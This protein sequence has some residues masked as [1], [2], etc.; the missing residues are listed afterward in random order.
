MMTNPQQSLR[1]AVAALIAAFALTLGA[2]ASRPGPSVLAPV[3]G[4]DGTRLVTVFVAS[5]RAR[6]MSSPAL[7]TNQITT[8]PSYVRY[9]ISIPPI[10][11]PTE[12]EWPTDLPDPARH[13]AVVSSEAVDE[14]GFFEEVGGSAGRAEALG[15]DVGIFVHG[16]N[17]SFQ[18]SLFR[19]AQL[20][21]D[22]NVTHSAVLFTWPSKAEVTAYLADREAATFSRD[23]LAHLIARVAADR[24]V[25]GV[26]LLAHSMGSW[27]AMEAIRQI[28]IAEDD[29][30]IAKLVDVTLAAP[31]I[32]AEVFLQQLRIIGRLRSP[33]T[34]LVS[35]ED[36]ALSLSRFLAGGQFRAGAADIDA[37]RSAIEAGNA[38]L[39]VIDISNLATQAGSGH[40]GFT[41]FSSIYGRFQNS[42]DGRVAADVGPGVYVLDVA[43]R[44]QTNG[45]KL[46]VRTP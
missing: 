36:Q 3:T 41:A 25:R 27:L 19:M 26:K 45:S 16:F 4:I 10:H 30:A 22:G 44:L 40:D 9:V 21:V 24:H 13:F 5:T 31:D 35:R 46:I 18:E 37:P 15:R 12:I 39:R 20:V 33:V 2:C 8:T 42:R 11:R 38:N 17:N 32:D 7:L 1:Y 23:A 43:D 34:V 14:K 29:R 28:R 6:E